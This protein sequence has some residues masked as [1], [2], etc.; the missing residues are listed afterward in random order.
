MAMAIRHYLQPPDTRCI[1]PSARCY[2]LARF[3][4]S[5]RIRRLCTCL[6]GVIDT[7]RDISLLGV[8]FQH[9]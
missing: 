1:A 6:L 4:A 2:H 9:A 5:L 8:I 7:C 3:L